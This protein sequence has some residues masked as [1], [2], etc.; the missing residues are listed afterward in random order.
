VERDARPVTIDKLEI[1]SVELPFVTIDVDCSKGTYIRTLIDDIGN[2][3]SCGAHMTALRRTRSGIFDIVDCV[4]LE[5]LKEGE[6]DLPGLLSMD[7]ALAE[8]P[9]VSVCQGAVSALRCGVPPSLDQT[10]SDDDI[11]DGQMV[12]LQISGSLAAMARFAPQREKEKRGDFELIRVF[13]GQ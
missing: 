1:V 5:K 6:D 13:V 12:R 2:Q 3:L 9:A 11:L 10:D 7:A 4:T 8:Y